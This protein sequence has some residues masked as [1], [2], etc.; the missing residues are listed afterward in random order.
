MKENTADYT[1]SPAGV[2]AYYDQVV[3]T[4]GKDKV[5]S[6]IRFYVN[7]GVNHQGNGTAG[8]GSPIPDRVDLLG[9][10]DRWVES[11]KA[12][13]ELTVTSYDK[14]TPLSSRPMCLYPRYPHYDGRGDP[15]LASSFSCRKAR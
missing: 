2:F 7:P 11:G 9:E 3:K 14:T 6:F 12:P 8:D 13:G 15:R 5:D 10:L 1:V 4:M